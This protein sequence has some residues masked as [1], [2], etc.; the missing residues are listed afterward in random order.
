MYLATETLAGV[1]VAFLIFLI[2]TDVS[3]GMWENGFLTDK[4]RRGQKAP[5]GK[6]A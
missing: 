5:A 2:L 4:R 3:V 6:W 1:S